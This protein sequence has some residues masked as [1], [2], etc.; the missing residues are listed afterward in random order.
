[1]TL[2][3]YMRE[4]S[5][6]FDFKTEDEERKA[7][8]LSITIQNIALIQ[9]LTIPFH[10]GLHVLTGETGAGKSIVVDAV[11]LV[12]GGRA[13]RELIR[14]GC[15]K[16]YVEA[17]FDISG[18]PQVS[19]L[20]A[21]QQIET[22]GG[23][24][25]ISRE[26][27]QSGR[28]I[29]RVMGMAMQLSYLRQLTAL[30]MDIHG[31]HEH[32]FLMDTK[33]HL[34]FLDEF[35]GETHQL[36]LDA[37][38]KSYQAFMI[39]HQ[40]YVRLHKAANDRE[41]RMDMLRFQCRELQKARLRAGEEEALQQARQRARHAEKIKEG[42]EAAYDGLYGSQPSAA[43]LVRDASQQLK[44]IGALDEAY[45]QLGSRMESLYYELEDAGLTL[46]DWL[47]RDAYD[48]ESAQQ[49]EARLDLISRLSRKY[50]ADTTAMVDYLNRIEQELKELEALDDTLE[51]AQAQHKKLLKAYREQAQEVTQARRELAQVFERRM[52][53]QL[54]ALGM[55]STQF[56]VSFRSPEAEGKKPT[57][58]L[59]GDDD[60]EFLIA[61]NPGEPLKPLSKI[62]SG[63]ELSRLMLAIKA[64]A[65]Q[66]GQI[67][68]MVFDEIDTG[69][70]G[71]MAQVVAEK[72]MAIARH[73]QVI[74][75]THLP[76]IAAMA[77]HQ[78]LV[79]KQVL[80][81]RTHTH[82]EELDWERRIFQIARMI[83][84]AGEG[85]ASALSHAKA[86]LEA[87]FDLKTINASSPEETR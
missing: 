74:C 10:R 68:S 20:L 21:Q 81:E 56:S 29:C 27:S 69:I 66:R 67:D 26:I 23:L 59:H 35:G 55:A 85:E 31:Q 18:Q 22:E 2:E 60:V 9:S 79:E 13:D 36:R 72:M 47:Q 71:R 82:V 1:M 57:P 44:A 54:G 19:Q 86:M 87:A 65:A 83:G 38:E 77:D 45:H 75:V 40:E 53:E 58:S 73:R 4:R 62:A 39:N 51:A 63:G 34:R 3:A 17:V 5:R 64:I 48:A 30:L 41:Q 33:R 52:M 28:N 6:I 15:D 43:A 78:Y 37:L 46:R 24:L 8:L 12:L 42:L 84:G 32:Q 50:G 49:V 61:P 76:Q 14:T 25:S 7:V 70:S 11:N 16:A 80:G